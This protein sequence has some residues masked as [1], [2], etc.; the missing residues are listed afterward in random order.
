MSESPISLLAVSQRW[1]R[2]WVLLAPRDH[3]FL[4]VWPLQ[5]SKPGTVYQIF[6]MLQIFE[7]PSHVSENTSAWEQ[8]QG[9]N[10]LEII[11]EL[12]LPC[13]EPRIAIG[14]DSCLKHKSPSFLA[15]F[16]IFSMWVTT[17]QILSPGG[18]IGHPSNPSS[19]ISRKL[20]CRAGTARRFIWS[21]WPK[22]S[23]LMILSLG[24]G[25][26]A[27]SAVC[28]PF[29]GQ[30]STLGTPRK[31]EWWKAFS[32]ETLPQIPINYLFSF[33]LGYQED[34]N[35]IVFLLFAVKIFSLDTCTSLYPHHKVLFSLSF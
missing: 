5:S 15:P 29:Q 9:T 32:P 14:P 2:S 17:Q 33:C 16:W 12:C 7:F 11:L 18:R 10:F 13:P 22:P 28:S 34:Q 1:G 3:T 30:P 21:S 23:L 6:L 25:Q 24:A 31:E 26:K 20:L 19:W 4:G 35:N 8:H 27:H